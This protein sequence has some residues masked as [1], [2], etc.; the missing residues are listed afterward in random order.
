MA[1]SV[2]WLITNYLFCQHLFLSFSSWLPLIVFRYG[3]SSVLHKNTP[4]SISAGCKYSKSPNCFR[5]CIQVWIFFLFYVSLLA[6][7][8]CTVL[9]VLDCWIL[10]Y[11]GK[12]IICY[13]LVL[14]SIALRLIY[15][16]WLGRMFFTLVTIILMC[17]CGISL[18]ILLLNI[19]HKTVLLHSLFVFFT[20]NNY[21]AM[22]RH[23]YIYYF[24][25]WYFG[26]F[27]NFLLL[28][29]RVTT[30]QEMF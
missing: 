9:N 13:D 11:G 21:S 27:L 16:K 22:L 8:N 14:V 10:D 28:I 20:P 18:V 23:E 5:S 30:L 24:V 2:A 12:E 17:I 29:H 7:C 4:W 3:A 26:S 19:G 15:F 1:T 6:H 25:S